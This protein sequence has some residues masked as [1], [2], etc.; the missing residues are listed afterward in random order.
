[1]RVTEDANLAPIE[2]VLPF[3]GNEHV[4]AGAYS[5][6]FGTVLAF[7][8]C[9]HPLHHLSAEALPIYSEMENIVPSLQEIAEDL[10]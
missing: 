4:R 1:M 7:A 2:V 9:L 5:T 8:P 6:F 3:P 10:S